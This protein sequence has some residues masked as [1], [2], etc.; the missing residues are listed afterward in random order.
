[1]NDDADA[2]RCFRM[3]FS[4]IPLERIDAG[5]QALAQ[6]VNGQRPAR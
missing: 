1:M 2:R 3:G 4:A 6:C 5:V